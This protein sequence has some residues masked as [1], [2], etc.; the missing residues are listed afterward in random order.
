MMMNILH[1]MIILVATSGILTTFFG[2][3][4][5]VTPLVFAQ[6]NIEISPKCGPESGFNFEIIAGGFKPHTNVNWQLVDSDENVPLSGYFETNG[7][8]QIRET[9]FADDLEEGHYMMYVGEDVENDG[10]V[11]TSI[12]PAHV[13]LNIP[14]SHKD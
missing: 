13:E 14:C 10:K 5:L 2:I 9:T 12:I 8:G 4:R 6:S 11:D 3:E 1:M 7:E